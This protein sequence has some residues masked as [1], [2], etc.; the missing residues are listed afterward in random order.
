MPDNELH[1]SRT[2]EDAALFR[3]APKYELTPGDLERLQ[4]LVTI[5]LPIT[6]ASDLLEYYAQVVHAAMPKDSTGIDPD[7]Y[8][9]LTETYKAVVEEHNTFVL[10]DEDDGEAFYNTLLSYQFLFK[11]LVA[12]PR[13]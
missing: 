3:Y 8:H 7:L 11:N 12:K 6:S 1:T 4:E 5:L 10:S 13:R 9:D 2:P